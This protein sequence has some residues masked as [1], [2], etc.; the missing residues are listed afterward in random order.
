MLAP[1]FIFQTTITDSEKREFIESAQMMQNIIEKL[2][3]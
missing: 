2:S 1:V 3:L